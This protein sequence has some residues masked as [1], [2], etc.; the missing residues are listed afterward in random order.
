MPETK[1]YE[2]MTLAELR[3]DFGRSPH[4][5][6]PIAGAIA[7]T[8]AGICGAALPVL[9]AAWAMFIFTGFTFPLAVLVGRVI[10]ESVTTSKNPLDDLLF[11]SV[12]MVSL[13]FA[14]AIPF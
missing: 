1:S 6:M 3:A 5:A 7:W 11:K 13:V 2:D 9:P 8:L 14:I 10:G 12:I 4:L